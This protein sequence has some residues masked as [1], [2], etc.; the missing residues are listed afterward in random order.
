[1]ERLVEVN[2]RLQPSSRGFAERTPHCQE[3][4]EKTLPDIERRFGNL[5]GIRFVNALFFP[6]IAQTP[7]LDIAGPRGSKR[8][9]GF[10]SAEQLEAAVKA[11]GIHSEG[12]GNK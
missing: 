10:C 8:I 11:V 4:R 2:R 9:V 3:L 1:M 5:V 12:E 6:D 7:T